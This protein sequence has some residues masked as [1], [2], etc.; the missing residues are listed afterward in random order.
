[1]AA[2]GRKQR[3]T[4]ERSRTENEPVAHQAAGLPPCFMDWLRERSWQAEDVY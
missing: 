4:E 3:A 2:G 1:M